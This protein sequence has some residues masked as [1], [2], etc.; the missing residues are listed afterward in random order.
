ML[1]G[2]PCRTASRAAFAASPPVA[3]APGFEPIGAFAA[4][5][6]CDEPTRADLPGMVRRQGRRL[7]LLHR[8]PHRRGAPARRAPDRAV[9]DRRVRGD[10][11]DTPPRDRGDHDH[12]PPARALSPREHRASP[13]AA[14]AGRAA[15]TE[16]ELGST[17]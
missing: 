13:G 3:L 9:L 15:R 8:L 17:R 11:V 7:A 12:P 2:I 6:I 1:G 16:V 14:G 10:A 4:L 5:V